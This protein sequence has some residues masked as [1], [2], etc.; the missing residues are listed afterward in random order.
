MLPSQHCDS[1]QFDKL[2]CNLSNDC[3]TTEIVQR[4]NRGITANISFT[5]FFL[6]DLY[7]GDDF[8][9]FLLVNNF[10]NVKLDSY[11]GVLVYQII[12]A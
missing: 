10:G 9:A 5:Y 4:P 1:C 6:K 12:R 8:Q 7:F 11:N 3:I 2:V